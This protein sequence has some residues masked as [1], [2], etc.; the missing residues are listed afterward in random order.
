MNLRLK[1]VR[2]QL[3]I[4]QKMAE[5]VTG[6]SVQRLSSYENGHREPDLDA[7]AALADY[8]GVTM[9]Y[10]T[11][12]ETTSFTL[13]L[14]LSLSCFGE[15]VEEF[16]EKLKISGEQ[17]AQQIGITL[18]ELELIENGSEIPNMN[19]CVRLLNALKLSPNVAF[20]DILDEG[21]KPKSNYIIESLKPLPPDM[22]QLILDN[23][24]SMI[25]TCR[26][27]L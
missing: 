20:M 11:G 3:K 27:R 15:R 25:R 5:E 13:S 10:L 6:I 19:V 24:Y 8:Y 14:P 16:R 18:E 23:L 22:R 2:E 26:A 9:D 7:L 12:R 21:Y 4:T 17:L 1:Q